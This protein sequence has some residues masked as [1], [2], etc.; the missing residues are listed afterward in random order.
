M[1]SAGRQPTSVDVQSYVNTMNHS[2]E[3]HKDMQ[4]HPHVLCCLCSFLFSY[5]GHGLQEAS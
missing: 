2:D 5:M 4:S 1:Y 3:M